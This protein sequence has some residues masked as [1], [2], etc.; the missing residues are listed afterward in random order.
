MG[1]IRPQALKLFFSANLFA[2]IEHA[3]ESDRQVMV[4]WRS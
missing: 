1:K 4:A 2:Q 3:Y